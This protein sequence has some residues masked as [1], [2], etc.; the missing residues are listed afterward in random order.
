MYSAGTVQVDNLLPTR[1]GDEKRNYH[2]FIINIT[3]PSVKNIL[4]TWQDNACLFSPIDR[5]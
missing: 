3:T 4:R 1:V 2:F 5:E